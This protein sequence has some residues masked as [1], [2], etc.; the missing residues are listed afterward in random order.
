MFLGAG[1]ALLLLQV[2]LHLLKIM[3]QSFLSADKVVQSGMQW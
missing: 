2:R 1:I 3:M